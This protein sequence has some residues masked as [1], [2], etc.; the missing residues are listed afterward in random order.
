M[1]RKSVDIVLPPKYYERINLSHFVVSNCRRIKNA[2]LIFSCQRQQSLQTLNLVV[3]LSHKSA[4][5]S[6]YVHDTSFE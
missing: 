6:V 2:D 5:H 4:I 3:K 1:M